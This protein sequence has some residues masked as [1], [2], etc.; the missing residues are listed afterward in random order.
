MGCLRY[1]KRRIR[2]S[3]PKAYSQANWWE[4]LGLLG[5]TFV[6]ELPELLGMYR[7]RSWLLMRGYDRTP[8][9]DDTED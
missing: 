2:I 3:W 9:L 5:T 1:L 4:R 7:A 8:S 6:C